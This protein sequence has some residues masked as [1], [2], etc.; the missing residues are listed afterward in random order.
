MLKAGALAHVTSSECTSLAPLVVLTLKVGAVDAVISDGHFD[1]CHPLIV[2]LLVILACVSNNLGRRLLCSVSCHGVRDIWEHEVH[3]PHQSLLAS[4]HFYFTLCTRNDAFHSTAHLPID[5]SCLMSRSFLTLCL[6][7][8]S[9]QALSA[10][11]EPTFRH[12]LPCFF[13]ALA[14]LVKRVDMQQQM[15][16]GRAATCTVQSVP[17]GAGSTMT[18]ALQ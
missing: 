8:C 10:F 9:A 11:D 14:R 17:H 15:C 7:A 1:L 3:M 6:T 12:H 18:Q 4:G 5:F 16:S 2:I 13:P